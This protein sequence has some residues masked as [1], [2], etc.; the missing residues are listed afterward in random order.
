MPIQGAMRF[1]RHEYEALIPDETLGKRI[2][3]PL[4]VV[5]AGVH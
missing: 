3:A 1:F 4:P 5:Q 2:F